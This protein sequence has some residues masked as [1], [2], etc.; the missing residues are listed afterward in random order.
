MQSF[1]FHNKNNIFNDLV[2]SL[3]LYRKGFIMYVVFSLPNQPKVT[4]ITQ[5]MTD[6]HINVTSIM[7]VNDA[8]WVV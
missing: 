2:I 6:R 7:G 8:F 1:L 5:K 4:L 3:I